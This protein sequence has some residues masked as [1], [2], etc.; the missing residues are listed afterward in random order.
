VT[1]WNSN[2]YNEVNLGGIENVEEK[3]AGEYDTFKSNARK[4]PKTKKR[5]TKRKGDLS[6]TKGTTHNQE[7]QGKVVRP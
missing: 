6:R 4:N 3:F 7:D 2:F 5:R 1:T